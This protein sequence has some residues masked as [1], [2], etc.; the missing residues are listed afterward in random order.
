MLGGPKDDKRD[1][2]GDPEGAPPA[3]RRFMR[4][5]SDEN[6]PANGTNGVP[7]GP[8]A[9]VPAGDDDEEAGD[10]DDEGDDDFVPPADAAGVAGD[11]G[12][13]GDAGGGS[14]DDGEEEEEE[15]EEGAAVV[16]NDEGKEV[17][18]GEDGEDGEDEEEDDEA[19]ESDADEDVESY[20]LETQPITRY[21]SPG[22]SRKQGRAAYT[23]ILRRIK[24]VMGVHVASTEALLAFVRDLEGVACGP[25]L[26]EAYTRVAGEPAKPSS[27]ARAG[28][29]DI[30]RWDSHQRE[31]AKPGPGATAHIITSTPRA[32]L[33][34][35]LA[36]VGRVLAAAAGSHAELAF[37]QAAVLEKVGALAPGEAAFLR[38]VAVLTPVDHGAGPDIVLHA[39]VDTTGPALSPVELVRQ[40][41]PDGPMKD[42]YL[43]PGMYTVVEGVDTAPAIYIDKGMKKFVA[44]MR[45]AK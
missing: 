10:D 5:G 8:P 34:P 43:A 29:A 36:E 14:E 27:L 28:R 11:A 41:F 44:A 9:A 19:D 37:D 23:P 30:E 12:D 26:F 38:N 15:E 7:A 4:A 18:D 32:T 2:I 35:F 13:A 33:A 6:A 1:P 39:A 45:S 17:E 3:K 25:V 16:D 31:A 40:L 42:C 20:E 21:D 24:D 22:T